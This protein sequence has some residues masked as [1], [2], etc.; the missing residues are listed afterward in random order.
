MINIK[1]KLNR[2]NIFIKRTQNENVEYVTKDEYNDTIA[3]V[4][5]IATT[6]YVT[7]EDFNTEITN[8][9]NE[10]NEL[11]YKVENT[12][13]G[14]DFS[15]IG[16]DNE[17]SKAING[18]I[19]AIE[20]TKINTSTNLAATWDASKTSI[21]SFFSSNTA[22]EYVPQIDTSNLTSFLNGFMGC[23][24]LVSIP[25]LDFS[26]VTNMNGVF[27]TA[28]LGMTGTS[29]PTLKY[30]GGFKNLKINWNDNF[31]LTLCLNLT[32]QS[33]MNVINNLYDFRANSDNTTTR[34]LKIHQNTLNKLSDE[35]IALATSKGWIL[36]A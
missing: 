4:E 7:E 28:I 18:D 33:I 22:L 19:I 31:G 25:L 16:Y 20:D 21:G 2:T 13:K 35:D 26:K 14:A 32:Y 24:S 5:E 30:M 34:T 17:M 23:I 11:I 1:D 8:I 27:K 3:E 29:L 36:T 9:N 6:T 15:V 10:I 12:V